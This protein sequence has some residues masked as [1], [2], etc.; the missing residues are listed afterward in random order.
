MAR[1]KIARYVYALL[2]E[3]DGL[4]D[5]NF[6]ALSEQ[7]M[8]RL[9]TEQAQEQIG[10]DPSRNVGGETWPDVIEDGGPVM[11]DNIIV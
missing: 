10:A 3:A 4:P 2:R 7:I 6:D 5:V 11:L 1:E 9:A 8:S